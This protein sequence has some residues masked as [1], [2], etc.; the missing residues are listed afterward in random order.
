MTVH[1][2]GRSTRTQARLIGRLKQTGRA[3][4]LLVALLL[5]LLLYPLADDSLV[6]KAIL[7]LSNSAI[8][9]TGVAAA[10]GS[11]ATLGVAVG[12]ALP[13]LCARMGWR[14]ASLLLGLIWGLWHLPLFFL[15]GSAQSAMPGPLFILNIVA[16]SVLFA[17]LFLRTNGSIVP[18]LVLHTSLNTW[19]GLLSVIP[20]ARSAGVYTLVTCLMAV[21]AAGLLLAPS[22]E[23]PAGPAGSR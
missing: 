5:L 21:I 2:G 12:F 17:W 1:R 9:I 3:T 15:A 4:W 22:C 7:G 19:A 16:G 20:T 11:R 6:W 8:L 10:S 14:P 13:A 18:A 23:P